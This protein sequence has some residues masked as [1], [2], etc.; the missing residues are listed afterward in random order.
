MAARTVLKKV[1]HSAAKWVV[2]T[3]VLKDNESVET[4]AVRKD[5]M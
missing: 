3:V 1:V 5:A 2:S 4:S